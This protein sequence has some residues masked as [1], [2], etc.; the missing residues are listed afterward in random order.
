MPRLEKLGDV[1]VFGARTAD[2][3][4]EMIWAWMQAKVFRLH[5]LIMSR[6]D[7]CMTQWGSIIIFSCLENAGGCEPQ[8]YFP[9]SSR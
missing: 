7:A 2:V 6:L 1:F 3:F 9:C 5:I 8:G 4:F